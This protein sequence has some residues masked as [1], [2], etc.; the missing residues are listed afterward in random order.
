MI[1]L[2]QLR[3]QL[4]SWWSAFVHRARTDHEIEAELQFHIDAHAQHLIEAG[5]SAPEA[6]RRARVEF[7][8]VDVQKEKYRSAI[9]VQPLHEIGGDIRYGLRSLYKKPVVS[10]VA[11][12]SLALGIGATTA[13]FSVIYAALLHPFPYA[14]ADRMVNP[15]VINEANPQTPT[16]FALDPS[17][18][19]S[20]R[21]AKS[22]DSVIGFMLGGLTATGGDLPEDVRVAYVTSN[23]SSFFGV[24]AKLGRDIQPFDV[25]NGMPP[26]NVVVLNYEFWQRKYNSDPKIVGH[27]LQ[28]NH[29]DYT[30]V[31]IMPRRFSFTNTVGTAD[32]YMPWT[33]TR[34][35]FLFPL[36]KL[37][38]GVSL[39]VAN[40][41][42]QSFLNEFKK[43]TPK[44]FPA[45]FHVSV[46][47]IIEPY[48][49]RTGRTLALL[50]AS[51]IVLLLIGCANCSI[52]L[53][54][55][56]ESRQHELAIRSAVGASRFRIVRQ[57][58]I[59][60]LAISC[61]G[62]AIG[63]AASFWLAGLPLR[64]MPG[65]FPQEAAIT[66]NLPIL[67]FS[68]ALALI[69]GLLFGLS[70]ALHLSRPNVSQVIQSTA[71]IAGGGRKGILNLLIGGQIA[72]TFVLLG[73][74]AAAIAGFMKITSTRLGYDPHNVIAVGIPLKRDTRKNQ[75]ER[76]TYVDQLRERVAAV[77]GVISVA[78]TSSGIPPS[79][80]LSEG[81]MYTPFEILGGQSSQER[82]AVYFLVG[83]E[84]FATL[85]IPMLSGRVWNHTENQR[86]DFVAVI[87]ETLARRDW[88]RGDA[89]G[90][91]IRI[92]SLKDDGTPLSAA[93]P[94]SGEW[95]QIVGVVADSK[96]N[97]LDQPTA[98]A[99]F[100]PYTTFM[101]DHTQLFIRTANSP[102]ASL[103]A[104][105][106]ALHSV[107]PEQRAETGVDDLEEWLQGQPIWAQQRLFSILFS[108]FAFLALALSSVGL[109][110]TI[111]FAIAR[112]RHELGVR[113]ALGAQR[114]HIVW[115]VVRATLG[116]V[117]SGIA[118]G[119]LFNLS[120]VKVIQHWSPGSVSAP[121]VFG[122]VTLLLLGSATIACLLPARQAASV[123]PMK[124]LRCD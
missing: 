112:R 94:Q 99:I 8:R 4:G 71:R 49:H 103:Q 88:P 79:L 121:W 39:S 65:T 111:T 44:H 28:L 116:A 6:A 7:G 92:A 68:V 33:A 70:P 107:D 47:P 83:S 53:F 69:T 89:I 122:I 66:I 93:S 30:I 43:E 109:A 19:D 115:I 27:V 38:A 105:R 16:W 124:T 2:A 23:A 50:F 45:L 61:A 76:A 82:Q 101:W 63:V 21:Q 26:S 32:V 85:K 75:V 10:V 64:L 12:I 3:S 41:E 106:T 81:G 113:M 73:S 36:I 57:L 24:P 11:V 110:S 118:L 108:F 123:D 14:G 18:F 40:A 96:N 98:P 86:G 51:V 29:Q 104:I 9:G 102:L 80:P 13:I 59:E 58:L 77:P 62:A 117:A 95:R 35:S 52:L 17:Q 72:L 1:P 54:A 84:Y 91:Q 20:F 15:A 67:A 37:K 97:G 48:V 87:N 119:L 100:V 46:Q 56:G 90:H 114:S 120:L 34:I 42:F 5:I 22:I 78:V 31:G 55:Y 25:T 74:A 60:S